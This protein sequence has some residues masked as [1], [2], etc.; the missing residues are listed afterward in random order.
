VATNY[1]WNKQAYKGQSYEISDGDG[2]KGNL[3]RRNFFSAAGEA[4]AGKNTFR[5]LTEGNFNRLFT[6]RDGAT[7]KELGSMEFRWVDFQRSLLKLKAGSDYTWRSHELLKGS[8]AWYGDGQAEPV[9]IFKLENLFHRSGVI[10]FSGAKIPAAERNLLLTLGLHLQLYI[11][12]WMVIA[13]LIIL[14]ALT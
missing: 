4:G 9:M 7:D 8:W 11:N 6:I 5:F 10:E 14:G 12:L 2:V 1:S 3:K 13:L